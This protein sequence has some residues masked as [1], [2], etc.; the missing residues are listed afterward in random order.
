MEYMF[1]SP[2]I[3]LMPH[4]YLEWKPKILILLRSRGLYQ[5]TMVMEVEP[6]SIDE[7][8]DFLNRGFIFLSISP[9]ILHQVYDDSQ[10]STPNELWMKLKVLFGNKEYFEYFM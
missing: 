8:N 1:Y 3:L 9:E 5:I 10:E 7:K 2:I 6:D 4:N